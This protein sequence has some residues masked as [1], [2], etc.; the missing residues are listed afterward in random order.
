MLAVSRLPVGSSHSS[1]L[2]LGRQGPGDGDALALAAGQPGR[3]GTRRGGRGRPGRA[4]RVAR[5]A[6]SRRGMPWYRLPSITFSSAER[7]GSRWNDWNTNPMRSARTAERGRRRR[8]ARRRRRRA[9]SRRSVGRSSRPS[10]LSSVDLPEPDGPTMATY[11]PRST[12][13][14][15]SRQR[16]HRRL[17]GEHPPDARRGR[18]PAHR[19]R[20][21]RAPVAGAAQPPSSVPRR[22][23]LV[24]G[25]ARPC[26]PSARRRPSSGR[27]C[28][29]VARAVVGADDDAVALGERAA[30]RTDLDVALGGQPDLD[31]DRLG[32]TVG[33]RGRP[34][35]RS[36]STWL[37]PS[38]PDATRR[39]PAPP[40]RRRSS[41]R[42]R[43]GCARR[44]RGTATRRPDRPASRAP[45]AGSNPPRRPRS[46]AG[47]RALALALGGRRRRGGPT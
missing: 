46:A 20:R 41:S 8:A 11:S 14:S 27:R 18:A 34:A 44:T 36:T 12:A 28:V 30:D 2:G 6:R 9:S 35:R 4:P 16:E 22:R 15:T 26:L 43:C 31:V 19:H 29:V 5:V 3:A 25:A 42:R 23:E 13:R 32:A 45:A 24:L 38:P 37:V 47:T 33:R 40:A 21:A 10:T 7:C 39:R 1:T 17:R